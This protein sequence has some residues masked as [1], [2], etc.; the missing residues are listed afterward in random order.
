M[1]Q[2]AQSDQE[3][4]AVR[5]KLKAERIQ[6]RLAGH[7]KRPPLMARELRTRLAQAPGWRTSVDG[8]ALQRTYEVPSIRAAGLLAQLLLTSGEDTGYVPD[9]DIRHLEVT[10]TVSTSSLQGVTVLDFDIARTLDMR[11]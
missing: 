8:N 2:A 4:P 9:V 3:M 11:L 10:V 6:E 5:S 1:T 7:N